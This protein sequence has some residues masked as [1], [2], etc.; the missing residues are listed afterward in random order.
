MQRTDAAHQPTDRIQDMET[1][2]LEWPLN[3]KRY[4]SSWAGVWPILHQYLHLYLE[5]RC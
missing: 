4:T 1:S 2:V 5:A 3:Q